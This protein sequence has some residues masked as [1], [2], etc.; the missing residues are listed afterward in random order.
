MVDHRPNHFVGL[1]RSASLHSL[2]PASPSGGSAYLHIGYVS[3]AAGDVLEEFL[4]VQTT[5]KAIRHVQCG[6]QPGNLV[7]FLNSLCVYPRSTL[8]N[9]NEDNDDDRPIFQLHTSTRPYL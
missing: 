2:D 3:C 1:H 7:F 9:D 8:T 5:N 4:H 6:R